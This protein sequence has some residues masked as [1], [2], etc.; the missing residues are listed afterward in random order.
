MNAAQQL[1][2]A[3]QSLWLDN[4]TRT[5]LKSGQLATYIAEDAVTGLTSNPSIFD[6]AI[7]GSNAYDD[8]ERELAASGLDTEAQ[9]FRLALDDLATAAAL[10]KPA[11]DA[12][13][14][15]DGWV[16]MEVSPRLVSDTAGS[17]AE[18]KALHRQGATPNLFIKIP[19]TAEGVPAIEELTFAG[20]PINVTLLFSD[21][22]YRAAAGAYQRGLQ[23]RLEAGLSL[24]VASVASLFVSRWDVATLDKLP[25]ELQ[26]RL[27]IAAAMQAYRSY[28]QM[29]GS[30]AWL[31]LAAQGARPQRLL[32]A[33]TGTKDP[34]KADTYYIEALA[35][36]DTINTI[37]PAT[38]EAFADHGKVGDMLAADGGDA[39]EVIARVE[40]AGIDVAV[41]ADTLQ[42][43][44]AASFVVAWEDLMASIESKAA[45]VSAAP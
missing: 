12:T 17:I 6:K 19:G 24:D 15:V 8:Q 22:Q 25:A 11:W 14:G 34:A 7:A 1:H 27:G 23:R 4:I 29:L 9:F 31:E 26:D 33:S 41:L 38:L 37:P 32:F 44:G 10:F 16:S 21:A 30:E 5:L 20:I 2:R 28:R 40:A 18:A 39:D 43:E 36:P 42:R 45:T 3:G 35:A 13:G